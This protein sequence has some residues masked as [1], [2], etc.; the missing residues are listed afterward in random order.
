[1]PLWKMRI[2]NWRR[3]YVDSVL[4]LYA[5]LWCHSFH[6]PTKSM[7]SFS[8]SIPQ[9]FNFQ[10]SE[11][12]SKKEKLARLE[13]K[14]INEATSRNGSVS[15]AREML[16]RLRDYNSSSSKSNN[17]TTTSSSSSN[18]T[19]YATLSSDE[20]KKRLQHIMDMDG[21]EGPLLRSLPELIQIRKDEKMEEAK[22]IEMKNAS[23]RRIIAGYQ[24]ILGVESSTMM[25][26]EGTTTYRQEEEGSLVLQQ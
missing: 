22:D 5:F 14:R 24:N 7:S 2:S 23:L 12:Q 17:D 15:A 1:M 19:V 18:W 11:L 10:H 8:K 20:M 9:Q 13:D 26:G 3:R 16:R 4:V 6:T 21:D 25:G